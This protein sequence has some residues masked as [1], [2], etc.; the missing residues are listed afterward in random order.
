MGPARMTLYAVLII[1]LPVYSAETSRYPFPFELTPEAFKDYIDSRSGMH[2][3][4][5]SEYEYMSLSNCKLQLD[6]VQ[7]FGGKS[8]GVFD[9]YVCAAVYKETTAL[10]TRTCIDGTLSYTSFASSDKKPILAFN[11][12]RWEDNRRIQDPSHCGAWE[13]V[14]SKPDTL[15]TE[16]SP[17][18]VDNSESSPEE[19]TDEVQEETMPTQ[20]EAEGG[21]TIS[22][23]ALLGGGAAL[24]VGGGV[25]TLLLSRLVNVIRKKN[26]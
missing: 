22:P 7:S 13:P 1:G 24:F 16:P 15:P 5:S 8:I 23:E 21:I 20:T 3:F 4:G 17:P 9:K 18:S 12:G 19:E 2:T 11:I 26:E 25:L 14:A 6:S 10:G